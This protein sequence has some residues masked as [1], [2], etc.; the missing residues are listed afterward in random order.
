M[1]KAHLSLKDG[2]WPLIVI[3]GINLM[4]VLCIIF[5]LRNHISPHFGVN[6][7]MMSSHYV[8]GMVDREQSLILTITAGDEPSYY[9]GNKKVEGGRKEL[10]KTLEALNA[11]DEARHTIIIVADEAVSVGNLQAVTDIILA[12]GYTCTLAARPPSS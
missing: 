1:K 10:N 12:H 7:R 11:E 3:A 9:L 4:L 2:G 5:V 8:M 6:V